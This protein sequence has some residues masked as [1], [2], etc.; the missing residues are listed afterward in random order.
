VRR[1][2]LCAVVLGLAGCGGEVGRGR[3]DGG[4][5]AAD[6]A[7][8][9][10]TDGPGGG[11]DAG[12]GS[13]VD[14]GGGGGLDGAG[15]GLDGGGGGEDGGLA[16][17]ADDHDHSG[18]ATYYQGANGTGN[19]GFDATPDDLMLGAMNHVDY[20]NSAVCGGCVRLT[21]PNATITIRMVDQCPECPAGNID[22]SPEAFALIADLSL[23]RVP[24]T[25]QYVS[26]GLAGPIRY[27]F[28]EGSNQWWT[29]VQIR[30]H[31]N[32]IATLEYRADDGAYRSVARESYN[33]FVEAAGMGPGPYAFRVT[34]VYGHVLEDTGV[35]FIEAGDSPGAGQF[36]A[37]AGP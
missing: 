29:A 17:Q 23:G 22:L 28:K 10:P 2:L 11:G 24:I 25:W 5:P 16:C 32:R 9:W 1:L 35:P 36:P 30:S 20:A 15:G 8:P 37:C 19:C 26:C 31:R 27:H 4:G 14:G 18:E 3:G 13:G 33:Y 12:G 6:G 21:G 7:L 34:D